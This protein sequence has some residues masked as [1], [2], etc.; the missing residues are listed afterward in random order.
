M[1]RKR[2]QADTN[3]SKRIKKSPP[4]AAASRVPRVLSTCYP[5][6][7]SLREYLRARLPR[8]STRRK[9]LNA[10]L[11]VPI[12]AV[13]D[14]WQVG[15][16]AEPCTETKR[17][18]SEDF[19]AFTQSQ[20]PQSQAH[21]SRTQTCTIDDVLSFVAWHLFNN[22]KDGLTRPNHVL[23]NGLQRG[24]PQEGLRL[25]PGIVQSH[26][27]QGLI[28]LK[29]PTWSTIFEALGGD[30]HAILASLLLDCGLFSAL[31]SGDENYFQVSGIPINMLAAS[32]APRG[33]T[34]AS[35]TDR[36]LLRNPSTITLVRNRMLYA[37]PSLNGKGCIRFGLK[38]IHVLQRY[39]N[40]G[41]AQETVHFL[42]HIF[43]RQFG[44]HN[45]FSSEID[46]KVTTQPF[47]DYIY[48][49]DEIN[50][51]CRHPKTWM[52]RRLRGACLQ[53]AV[54]IRRRH[55]RCA[56]AQLLRHYC[57][58]G[59]QKT[60]TN[61]SI[62]QT[63][64]MQSG[65][66]GLV[67]QSDRSAS[68]QKASVRS[69]G[70]QGSS[71][72]FLSYATPTKNVVNFC[73]AVMRA[74]LPVSAFGNGS[75]S[76]HNWTIF[77]RH[78]ESFVRMRRFESTTLHRICQGIRINCLSWLIPERMSPN[79]RPSAQETTKRHQLLT[80]FMY[81]VFDSLLIPLLQTNF[82]ITEV[83][84]QRNRIFY[85]RHDVWRKLAEP[86][87]FSLR[88]GIYDSMQPG[89][90]KAMLNARSLG[91]SQV[92][93]LPK[94][95]G[96]RT[97]T[98]LRR[99]TTSTDK[100]HR[101]LGPSINAQLTPVFAS[102][103]SERHSD[104]SLLGGAIFSISGLHERLMSFK[105]LIPPRSQLYFA[106]VDVQ[107][108][109]DSIPQTELLEITRT[110]LQSKTY[111][112]S[113]YVELKSIEIDQTRP[114]YTSIAGPANPDP[115]FS[116]KRAEDFSHHKTGRVF[117]EVGF[118]RHWSDQRLLELLE[119]HVRNN[120]V[121]IGKKHYRQTQGIPQGSV[122]SSLLC[123]FFYTSFEQEHLDFLDASNTL[124]VRLIDD[125][126]LVTTD[127]AQARRFLQVMTTTHPKFGLTVN[128]TKTLANFDVSVRSHKVSRN[129][130]LHFPF[131]GLTV[132]MTTLQIGK[133]RERKDNIVTNGLTVDM[134]K[135]IGSAFKR[136]VRLSL[137][138]QLL[139][140]LMDDTLNRPHW[141]LLTLLQAF[142]ETA[143]KMYAYL[144]SMSIG[145]RPS[146]DQVLQMVDELLR[147]G[148]KCGLSKAQ[149]TRQD[150]SSDCLGR[151]EITWALACS[152]EHV[153][154]RKQSKY[155]GLLAHVKA[156]K[157][158]SEAGLSIN[159]KTRHRLTAE[160][161]TAF[162][163]YVY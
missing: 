46:K 145:S 31:V 5:T 56:Y 136:K 70:A 39:P 87:L 156:L 110:I 124:L 140:I 116:I 125:F 60:S 94:S 38:H 28:S 92:R 63:A 91:Y 105:K 163:E 23:C 58:L 19:A 135:K 149:K 128:P 53:L 141:R 64:I 9:Q 152:F 90:V 143:I 132:S 52:P 10:S 146:Q 134:T 8:K 15:V 30:G 157:H 119:Q 81:Y 154:S 1:K 54:S 103:S 12:D 100:G 150:S 40:A 42:K 144:H 131:C 104:P 20:S 62:D 126:L 67:T 66:T 55:A 121:K 57:A 122:L 69:T 47:L 33:P 25:A 61:K 138:Q 147:L 98:N 127:K 109:F 159:K 18:R 129:A 101:V 45:V 71:Q 120:V 79:Q 151:R 96:S 68:L 2:D 112:T 86:S 117:A 43:P 29:S 13:L 16:L 107:S 102:L 85:F 32:K 83:G 72:S 14:A 114:K 4:D 77:M 21:T 162:L 50:A 78:L 26:P 88:N 155:R 111:R 41:N 59:P 118:Q 36:S 137:V 27:N 158:K 133:D 106:K 148:L 75:N 113:K 99:R 161:N 123:S 65:S 73:K 108:C 139:R 153:F 17:A 11:G 7:L 160:S 49:E 95:E 93:L 48:R 37:K 24:V 89:E 6:V 115:V 3:N 74:L 76:E 82:Y 35:D 80:E 142:Q 130:G 34:K 84:T 97:I 44:L 22:C 51:Q